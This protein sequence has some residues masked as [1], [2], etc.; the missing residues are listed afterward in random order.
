MYAWFWLI[1]PFEKR[2]V[3]CSPGELCGD[4]QRSHFLELINQVL[5]PH[6]W[7]QNGISSKHAAEVQTRAT[8]SGQSQSATN[9]AVVCTSAN[10]A[11]IGKIKINF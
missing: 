7:A 1:L 9:L 8:N 6:G 4:S 11:S 5:A 3:E 2:G 10:V